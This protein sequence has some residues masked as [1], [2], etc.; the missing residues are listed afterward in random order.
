[1]LRTVHIHVS[2]NDVT[3]FRYLGDLLTIHNCL[4]VEMKG[5]FNSGNACY[6]LGLPVS[7]LLLSKNVM[8]KVYKIVIFPVV[9][10]RCETWS[11]MLREEHWLKAFANWVLRKNMDLM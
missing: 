6:H 11:F 8:V 1:M 4:C 10:Y 7:F 2:F 9:L 3:Q 5:K